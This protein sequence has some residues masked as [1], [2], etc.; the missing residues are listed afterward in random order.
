LFLLALP[1]AIA[2]VVLAHAVL[3]PP[4]PNTR[5]ISF[6]GLHLE[7]QCVDRPSTRGGQVLVCA[8]FLHA[9]SQFEVLNHDSSAIAWCGQRIDDLVSNP[10]HS[11]TFGP[12][13]LEWYAPS[14][15]YGTV[16]GQIVPL[17]VGVYAHMILKH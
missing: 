9:D 3:A 5:L 6:D 11:Q 4:I 17:R 14:P 12:L 10:G 2:A 8:A 7:S 13:V 15:P 16:C 1:F